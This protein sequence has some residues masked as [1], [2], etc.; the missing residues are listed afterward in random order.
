MAQALSGQ[1]FLHRFELEKSYSRFARSHAQGQRTMRRVRSVHTSD[2]N[3][4]AEGRWFRSSRG[5]TFR[6]E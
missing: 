1:L 5:N 2:K 3:R 4:S 6:E